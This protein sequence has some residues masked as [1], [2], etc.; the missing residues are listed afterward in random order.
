MSNAVGEGTGLVRV[1]VLRG[2]RRADL[3]VPAGVPVADLLPELVGSVGALDPYTVHGGYRLIRP[4]GGSLRAD[5]TLAAQGVED[6][7]VLSVEVGAEVPP[8]RVY[9][10]VVEAVA[11]AVERQTRPWS[12]AASARTALVTAVLALL[13]AAGVLFTLR[14][15]G[16]PVALAAAVCAVLL[17]TTAAVLSRGQAAHRAGVATA[18]CAVP[19]AAVAG[20]A[21]LPERDWSGLPLLAAGAAVVVTAGLGVAALA[22]YRALLVPAL[23]L[24]GLA[25][26]V[27]ALVLGGMPVG[28]A[29]GCVLALVVVLGSVVPWVSLSTT[30][31][32]PPQPRSEAEILADPSPLDRTVVE[33][34]VR[35]GR[36][37]LIALTI[38]VGAVLVLAAPLV[39]GL[40]VWGTG[41]VVVAA[42]VLVLRA[43]QY[44]DSGEVA[45]TVVSAVAALAAAFA[46]AALLHDGWRP[47]LA[48]ILLA[49]GAVLVAIAVTPRTP[50]VR[51]GR[52][53][54]VLEAVA[55]VALLPLLVAALGFFPGAG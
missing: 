23:A 33:R 19:F 35:L 3:A 53:A 34:Q 30:R 29:A 7:E 20:L 44:R 18:W 48:G 54:D 51:L 11:D 10:D 28:A 42:V 1:T 47:L 24:A 40:G 15:A 37:V 32:R 52:W 49:V 6:G 9:D 31:L 50:N 27:A 22:S 25:V 43:R 12:P 36:E 16:T 26:A 46:A 14:T 55:L 17:I 13:L 39:V 45:V 8:P 38:T 41:L 5:D 21:A 2:V 4:A